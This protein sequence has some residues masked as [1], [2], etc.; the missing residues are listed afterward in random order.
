MLCESKASILSCKF[1]VK[2]FNEQIRQST[3]PIWRLFDISSHCY[4]KSHLNFLI[5]LRERIF[6]SEDEMTQLLWV[7][8][9]KRFFALLR[10][11][12]RKIKMWI[13]QDFFSAQ[14]C[15]FIFFLTSPW[16]PL[17]WN[18]AFGRWMK[19]TI[20]AAFDFSFLKYHWTM[21]CGSFER[22]TLIFCYCFYLHFYI[23]ITKNSLKIRVRR[24]FYCNLFIFLGE[25]LF[26]FTWHT[27]L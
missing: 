25:K 26:I 4:L 16:A 24:I 8:T 2:R 5:Y 21:Y 15:I 7:D 6:K 12:E 9:S 14:I 19:G 23:S 11:F 10:Y 13:N 20:L 22:N 17:D 27:S 1:L 3:F 18:L